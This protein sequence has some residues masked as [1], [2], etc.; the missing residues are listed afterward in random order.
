MAAFELDGLAEAAN[1]DEEFR[2]AAR[3]WSATLRL[4]ADGEAQRIR[5]EDG[6]VTGA[7]PAGEPGAAQGEVL[8]AAPAADWREF[9]APVPRP[10]YQDLWGALSHHG[11][12]VEGDLDRL[13]PWYPAAQRLFQLLREG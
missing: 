4:E 13:W 5:I 6:R 10:F 2:I 9:L 12:R 1:L 7:G 3:L 8:I 11:F